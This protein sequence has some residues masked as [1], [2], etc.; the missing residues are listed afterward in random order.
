[1]QIVDARNPLLFRC[2]DLEAYVAELDAAGKRCLLLVNKADLLSPA[3]REA[4]AA[5]F[6]ANGIEFIFW[7]AVAAQLGSKPTAL[8]DGMLHAAAVPT[9]RDLVALLGRWLPPTSS[10]HDVSEFCCRFLHK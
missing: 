3:Q 1:M 9:A 5:H 8:R 10:A 2:E 7:S 6:R 4:W